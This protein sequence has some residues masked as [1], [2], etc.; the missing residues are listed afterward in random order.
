MKKLTIS[1]GLV[2][3]LLS[4]KAQ[5]TTCT[6]FKGKKVLEFNYYT[7]EVVN[8]TKDVSKC[9]EIDVK[10]GDILCLDFLDNKKRSRLVTL[11]FFDGSVKTQVLKSKD[12]FYYTP[13]GVV[14]VKVSTPKLLFF[15]KKQ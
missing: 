10:Y 14:K 2:A 12:H 13:L 15:G 5:D 9:Y 7:S 8:T 1:I 11:T 4:A 3:A 6:M